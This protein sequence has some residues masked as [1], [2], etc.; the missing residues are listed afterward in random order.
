MNYEKRFEFLGQVG[1]AM[2]SNGSGLKNWLFVAPKAVV[3]ATEIRRRR[4][5]A[6]NSSG[7]PSIQ[8]SPRVRGTPRRRS[9][10]PLE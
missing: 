4:W 9:F 5:R 2:G 3:Q 8:C 10:G 7:G 1:K 6:L